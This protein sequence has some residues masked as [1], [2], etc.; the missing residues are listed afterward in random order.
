MS[1]PINVRSPKIIS[2][3]GVANDDIRA[4]I[5]LWNDPASQPATPNFILEKPIPS[6]IITECHFDIS[7]YCRGFIEHIN[8]VEVTTDTAANVN[9]Y[10][11]CHVDVYR[12]GVLL[13]A[14]FDYNFICFDGFGYHA[15]GANPAHTQFLSDGDYY[16]NAVGN[17]GGVYYY[18]DQS[19]TWE[20]RYTDL[21]AGGTTTTITLAN[22][23][24]YIPYVHLS[25]LTTGNKL[26]IIRD[27][28]VQNTYYFYVQS[29]CKYETINCDFVNKFGAWQ[30]LVF[31][32]ASQESFAMSNSEYN[33][34]PEDIDYNV[35]RNVRQVFNVNGMDKITVNTG[36]VFES[37]SEV[38]K[39]LLLS[40]KILLDDK[41]VNVDTKSLELQKNIN[42]RNIN[43][44]LSFKYSNPTLNYNI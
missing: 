33:L 8:Y 36:W 14:S 44:N 6:S 37:Y 24:G 10:A 18:D 26:E 27:S 29:E 38:M 19:V 22:E 34:M 23:V 1:E 32:K 28:V 39:Q 16:V 31:F 42:N 25:Y 21:A 9:E 7:P 3:T 11:Y 43:Y 17:S 41:P 40:E 5:F 4:E 12:N 20:A 30:R 15:E 13:L 35:K 2:A